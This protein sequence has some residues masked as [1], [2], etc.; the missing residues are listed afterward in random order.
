MSSFK[1]FTEKAG[2]SVLFKGTFDK[3]KQYSDIAQRILENL[4]KKK[5][6]L[7]PSDKYKLTFDDIENC[8]IPGEVS[9]GIYDE[10]TYSFFLN[11]LVSK[12]IKDAK[13]KFY[14]EK[15]DSFPKFEKKGYNNLVSDNLKKYWDITLNDI[16][17]YLN[18]AELDKSNSKFNMLL[19]EQKQ[20]EENL[21]KIKH[22]NVIC[23]NCF[24][25]DFCG[26]RFICS[27][28]DNYNLCQDCEKILHEKEIHPREH[29]LIQVTK[30]LNEDIFKYNNIIGNY[31]KEFINVDES[32]NFEFV[33]INNGENNLQNCYILPIRYGEEYLFCK[34]KKITDSIQRSANSKIS[35]EVKVPKKDG[36]FEGF[37]RM[38]TPNG[39][40]FG[41]VIN[42]KVL[43]GNKKN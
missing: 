13:Y 19:E 41:N 33:M 43:N 11:K 10:E 2:K 26:K 3:Y 8:Y 4:T 24:K 12:G 5:Q 37:F 9:Q 27:E 15:V 38:F 18:M 28:C 40:P 21:K 14:I 32:F 31:R 23:S 20:N 30:C 42:I 36:Y 16:T 6:T 25:K 29:V 22:D 34:S 39:I 17:S 35:L 7:K 1:V